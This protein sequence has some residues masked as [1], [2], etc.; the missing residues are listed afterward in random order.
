MG[1]TLVCGIG[2]STMRRRIRTG[3]C[4]ARALIRQINYII[5]LHIIFL[6]SV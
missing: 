5:Y 3:T 6:N 4:G 1:L 2:I